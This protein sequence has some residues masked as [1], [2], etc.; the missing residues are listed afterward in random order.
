ML[1]YITLQGQ[2]AAGLPRPLQRA[3]EVRPKGWRAAP[4]VIMTISI[5][6]SIRIRIRIS[7]SISIGIVL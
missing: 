6:I 4:G 5:S 2:D 3:A 1:L 7:I